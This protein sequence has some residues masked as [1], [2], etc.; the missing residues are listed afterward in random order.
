MRPLRDAPLKYKLIG[1]I[2]LTS[3]LVMLMAGI[4]FIAYEQFTFRGRLVRDFSIL[5]LLGGFGRW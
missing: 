3:V 4:S 1:I 5:A 2:M